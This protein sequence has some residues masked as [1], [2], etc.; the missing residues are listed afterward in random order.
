LSTRIVSVVGVALAFGIGPSIGAQQPVAPDSS[1]S[2]LTYRATVTKY[3]V[4]CHN[5][6]TKTGGLALDTMDFDNIPAGAAVWEKS[7]KKMRVGMM[8][9]PA[10]AQPDA[11]TRASLISWLTTR[12]DRAAIEKPNPGRPVLHRLNR[13]EYANAV[14]DL[15]AL[16]VDPSTLL[17]PDDSAYG[18]D[19]V[20]DVLGMSPVLLERFMEAANKVGALAI[21]DP[22]IGTAAQVFHIRQDASQ[23]THVEGLPIGTVGGI[24]AKVTLPLD[25]EY[26][27]AVKMFRT[28]LGVMRGLEYEHEMEYTVDGARVHTFRMGGEADF[29]A[30][31]VNMTKAGDVIDERGRIKLKLTA[32][33]HMIGAAFI[34]RSDAPNPTRLQPFIRS[35]TDT[36]DT[37]GHP[38]FDTLTVTGPF[39]AT[40]SGDTPSRRKIFSCGRAEDACAR[41]IISRLARLAYR[42]DVTDTDTQRLFAFF[43]AGRKEANFDRGIQ[44]VLQRILASPKFCFHIEQ[45]PAGLP[46]GSVYR[47]NDRELAA[48][49]SFF[50]WSSIPD[51]QLLDLAAQNKLHAPA[52]LEQQVRRMLADPRAEALS[53]N[54]AGQ[55]LYLR[56]LK[57]MQPNSEEFPDFDDNL[58]QAFAHEAELFFASI[59]N[60]DRNVLD[61]MTADYTFLN[62]RLAQHYRVPNVYGSHFRRVTLTDEARR[63]L[64]GK[65]AVLMVTSHVD[66][67]SPVVRGKWVLE[68]LLSAPVPPMAANV[69]PLNEDPNRGGRIL[70][71]RERMEEHRRNPACAQCHKIMDPIGLSLENFD[72]VGAWRTRDGDSVTGPGTP[73]DAQGE[74]LDG[75]RVNGV[76]TLRQALLRQPELFV[77]TVVEKL[78]IYALGRGLQPYDMPSVRSIVRDTAQTNYRFSSIVMGIITSTPFQKRVTLDEPVRTARLVEGSR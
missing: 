17:P 7:L 10:A 25:A 4:T 3:C 22:D 39:S 9:P 53:T 41:Q 2:A 6:R 42:G 52:V 48:R 65:G 31:L 43:D 76:N 44:K 51:T 30:N 29:K 18:F 66:R 47:I 70:T 75:T 5:D 21:G 27:I 67:T 57:N 15:L 77:G 49:L 19:N 37:S 58:R 78:M 71:M 56:N 32:G 73:I 60:E 11:A 13:A 68:N 36:R 54:F 1:S 50:L 20:G 35:S 46:P 64:L 26:Q 69:P 62:E 28:N 55:W 61:L 45:D 72:A 12:L 74:L 33:P 38:H 34:A 8:P 63:G 40:G 59:V 23:D 16:E 24:V 14:R